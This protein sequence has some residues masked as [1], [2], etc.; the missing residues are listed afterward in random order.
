MLR[1]KFF[2]LGLAALGLGLAVPSLTLVPYS[3]VNVTATVCQN[4]LSPA[5]EP[6]LRTHQAKKRCARGALMCNSIVI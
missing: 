5:A 1:P 3:L 2:G 6:H 4:R